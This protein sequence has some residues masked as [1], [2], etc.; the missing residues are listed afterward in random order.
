MKM[1]AFEAKSATPIYDD[2]WQV[3]SSEYKEYRFSFSNLLAFSSNTLSPRK[4]F[5]KENILFEN[6]IC[7]KS[8]T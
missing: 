1:L 3:A 4:W 8:Y 6:E 7:S 5:R 2:D